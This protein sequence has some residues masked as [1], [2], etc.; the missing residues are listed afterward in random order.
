MLKLVWTPTFAGAPDSGDY[1]TA[2]DHLYLDAPTQPALQD[3]P[4]PTPYGAPPNAALSQALDQWLAGKTRVVVMVHGYDFDPT[5]TVG[6]MPDD[7]FGLVYGIPGQLF[8]TPP[9][10]IDV[11]NSWLPLVGET[12]DTGKPLADLA[13]AFAWVSK[14]SFTDFA[15]ACWGNA[16]QYAALDAVPLAS[17]ALATVLKYIGSKGVEIDILAHSLGTRLTC[18]SIGHLVAGT[19][20]TT[21]KRIV[22]LGGAEFCVDASTYLR[23]RS[24]EVFNL[25][26]R[27]DKVLS[28]GAEMGCHPYRFNNTSVALVIGREGLFSG[29]NWLDIQVDSIAAATWL[30]QAPGGR[31]YAVSGFK[32]SDLHSAAFLNHWVY[33]MNLGNR[34]FVQALVTDRAMTISWFRAN[35][36]PE[37]VAALNYGQAFGPLPPTYDTC[38]ARIDRRSSR[39]IA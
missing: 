38:I 32:D 4:K 36:F 9:S 33:Y 26:N 17:K 14:D 2:S 16:Y 21:I 28:L 13:L 30:A 35:G 10:P 23:G 12:D 39:V 27:E 7:P 6:A 8:G 34:A 3:F 11:R 25:A 15:D 1:A 29:G 19:D 5:E 31:S 24:F 37:G 20:D 18:Q 22:F